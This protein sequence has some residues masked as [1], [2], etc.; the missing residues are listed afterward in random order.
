MKI[1]VI[2][3]SLVG[4]SCARQLYEDGHQVTIIDSRAE[5]GHPQELPGLHLGSVDLLSLIHI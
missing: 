3:S 5:I 2:G 4:L 1:L